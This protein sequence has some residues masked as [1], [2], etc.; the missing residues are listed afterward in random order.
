MNPNNNPDAGAMAREQIAP[1]MKRAQS[2]TVRSQGRSQA[3]QSQAGRPMSAYGGAAFSMS[4]YL[5]DPE[6]YLKIK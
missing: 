4:K 6:T 1:Y 5:H 2:A 3:G